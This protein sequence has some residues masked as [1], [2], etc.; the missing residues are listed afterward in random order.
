MK[1]L[2]SLLLATL[3]CS[4]LAYA[5]TPRIDES[6][7]QYTR[8]TP[9]CA[10]GLGTATDT[11]ARAY[12]MID[13]EHDV[14]AAP[15]SIYEAGSVSKQVT[16]AAIILLALDGKLSLDDDVR[17]HIPE[18]PDYGTTI[19]LRHLLNHTSGLRDW[20]SIAGIG[21][22]P[23]T[24][25]AYNN[26][27]VVDIASRQ[28]ALNYR[29]GD[30]YSYTNTGYN[31]M[32]VI[33]ARVSGQSF[34]DFTRDRIFRPLDMTSTSWRDD[35][36]RI[37]KG[38][39]IAYAPAPTG[40]RTDMPFE[41]AHGNGGL[42]TTVQDLLRFT[43]NLETG[44]VGGP[45]FIEAMHRQGVLNSGKQ[46]T[47]AS[48]LM[49]SEWRGLREVSHSGATA[50][51][52]AFLTRLPERKVAVAVLCNAANANATAL[53]RSVLEA[54][55]DLPRIV[56]SSAVAVDSTQVSRFLG[57]YR[58]TRFGQ[59]VRLLVRG[60]RLVLG[61]QQ[62][63]RLDERR[64]V[65]ANGN[66]LRFDAPRGVQ[67]AAFDVFTD[68]DSTR[69]VPVEPYAP[70][71]SS[72]RAAYVGTYESDEAEVRYTVSV[73]GNVLRL[74]DRYGNARPLTPT[75][76]DSFLFGSQV[77]TFVRDATG[78]VVGFDFGTDRAWAVR[79]A[80]VTDSK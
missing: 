59:P 46:I 26:R 5:Q 73:E 77:V 78:Q 51:Y 27:I 57:T 74:V 15:N 41:G 38:R 32:A 7:S 75:Y 70:S 35:H 12:G 42:L 50:G 34:S 9:G 55:V 66:E 39:A 69:Y 45:R 67:R 4:S 17:K 40:W 80:R 23:R 76:R 54:N 6:F 64:F 28:R 25:R 3:G 47:Y 13:L 11:V 30:H 14:P 56:A 31:L 2:T 44:K 10:V 37:V 36:T 24:T 21:G 1:R 22:W 53:A 29:P 33:V 79:F 49:I 68:N 43:H 72:E 58:S 48:G 60:G 65:A 20:G 63:A 19:T 16:A 52:R 71:T 8:T 62:F 18:L 61:N